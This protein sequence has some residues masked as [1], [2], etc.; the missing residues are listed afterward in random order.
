MRKR[1]KA[2]IPGQ[3]WM[4]INMAWGGVGKGNW[5]RSCKRCSEKPL[6][7]LNL[8]WH[9]INY[10]LKDLLLTAV[11]IIDYLRVK[12]KANVSWRYFARGSPVRYD[13]VLDIKYQR[14]REWNG[15]YLDNLDFHSHPEN[16]KFL[17]ILQ[18]SLWHIFAPSK[19]QLG[20]SNSLKCLK[21]KKRVFA[22]LRERVKCHG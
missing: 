12:L 10:I 18:G 15:K 16:V 4:R 5:L 3:C 13:D 1:K 6:T 21:K 17:C 2:S 11:W 19:C 14:F 8:G 20:R 22:F 7:T 9:N